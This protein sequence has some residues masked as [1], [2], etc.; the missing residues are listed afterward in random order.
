MAGGLVGTGRQLN[1][2]GILYARYGQ[3]TEAKS[4]FQKAVAKDFA[5]A[6]TNLANVAFLM[7]D[8]QTA[9][10]FFKK[11]LAF[12]PNNGGAL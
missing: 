4:Q 7:D 2:L 3:Y 12:N 1:S 8:Y 6:I 10:D 11:S 5:P 9:A